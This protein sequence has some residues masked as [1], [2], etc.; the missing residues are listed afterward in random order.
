[1]KVLG[2]ITSII[3][4]LTAGV[5]IKGFTAMKL[6]AWFIAPLFNVP[7][8]SLLSAYGLAMFASMIAMSKSGKSVDK[9]K[10]F[11]EQMLQ[12]LIEMLVING[13]YLGLGWIVKSLM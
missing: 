9:D 13:M 3:G 4:L 12:S 8:L 7:E 5:F 10:A 1:M 11:W 6:W 2:Y